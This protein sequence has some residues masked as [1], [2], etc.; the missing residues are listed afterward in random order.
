MGF[1]DVKLAG[2]VGMA[3]AARGWEAWVV[4]AVAGQLLAALYALA[5]LLTRRASRDTEFP[6]GPFMLLGALAA[7]CLA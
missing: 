5:L 2:L 3:A 7:V 4:A 1:G 6:L